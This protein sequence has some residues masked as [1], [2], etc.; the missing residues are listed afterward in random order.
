MQCWLP[1]L[2]YI[3]PRGFLALGTAL[4]ACAMV[5]LWNMVWNS[6]HSCPASDVNGTKP[7]A[8]CDSD[9][10]LSV[11]LCIFVF[12]PG[13]CCVQ[14]TLYNVMLLKY[15]NTKRANDKKKELLQ[16]NMYANIP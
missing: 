12:I 13:T 7:A 16:E 11:V 10:F 5:T 8:D 3:I 9:A 15:R 2:P 6:L 1:W 4:F 14:C